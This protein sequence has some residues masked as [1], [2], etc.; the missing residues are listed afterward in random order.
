MSF[1][2]RMLNVV[3]IDQDTQL[4]RAMKAARLA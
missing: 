4:M 1:I 3:P 2:A